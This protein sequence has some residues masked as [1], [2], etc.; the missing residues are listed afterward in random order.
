MSQSA[1]VR[2]A[3]APRPTARHQPRPAP[4]P[5]RTQPPRLR[6]VTAPPRARSRAGLMVVCLG[7]LALGLVG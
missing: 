2:T 1:A 5:A 3:G 6:I 7:L 4:G